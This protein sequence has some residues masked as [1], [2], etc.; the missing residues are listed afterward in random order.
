MKNFLG[1]FIYIAILLILVIGVFAFV[2]IQN[3]L[4]TP[5]LQDNSHEYQITK[6]DANIIIDEHNVLNI[7]ETLNV[8]FSVASHGIF[9]AIPETS[10]IYYTK[11]NGETYSKKYKLKFEVIDVNQTFKSFTEN[12]VFYIQ[13]GSANNYANADSVYI[14]NYKV[15]LGNDR[16]G[17]FDQ[18]YYNVLGNLT[19]TTVENV[20]IS[21]KF[22]KNLD[23]KIV[24]SSKAFVGE[25]GSSQTV[26]NLT[27]AE[28][29]S[30]LTLSYDF[31]DVGEGITVKVTLPDGYF[32]P[33]FDGWLVIVNT[34]LIIALA[35]FAIYVYK[36][37]STKKMVIPV[38]QFNVDKKYT[39]A[40]VGYIMDKKVDNKDVASLI[41]YW[42]QHGYL[43]IVE[44][45]IK[46]KSVTYLQKVKDLPSSAK[47]YEKSFFDA[48]FAKDKINSASGEYPLHE[49]S[50]LGKNTQPIMQEVKNE[51]AFTNLHLFQSSGVAVRNWLIFLTGALFALVGIVVNLKT[52]SIV[53][54][55]LSGLGGILI[56]LIFYLMSRNRDFSHFNPTYKKVLG[57]IGIFI[58]FALLIALMILS[59]DFYVDFCF[60]CF[61]VLLDVVLVFCIIFNFNIRTTEGV[62]ELG[63][64]VGLKNFIEATEK[65]RLNLMLK[66]DPSI[67]YNVLPYAYVLGVYDKWC[68]KFEELAITPPSWYV[69]YDD[70]LIFNSIIIMN[71]LDNSCNSLLTSINTVQ[72]AQLA[73]TVQDIGGSI[74]G[75][76]GGGFSGGG[77]GGGGVG[78][79]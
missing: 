54:A 74:G 23:E 22:P 42:A 26:D 12:G 15:D 25:F 8:H 34:I 55:I 68:K 35:V 18:F 73:K 16:I 57:W 36:K 29:N 47:P 70:N 63:D 4:S 46:K 6:Y 44:Q 24:E 33:Y 53:Y 66:E 50:S 11:E 51:I 58:V 19:D 3:L 30:L 27:W 52:V 32:N 10:T 69:T 77:M 20:N 65:D 56:I 41:I 2:F 1:R 61:L 45:K 79:W 21:I 14:L 31:L 39:S 72:M 7:T 60:T 43:K 5:T 40:D 17:E 37:Y 67:F 9:R 75:S 49:I 13:V 76:V 48:I 64:I 38:I 59:F 71:L 28:N 78:R 62:E